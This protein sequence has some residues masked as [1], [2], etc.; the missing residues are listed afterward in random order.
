MSTHGNDLGTNI[1]L[2]RQYFKGPVSRHTIHEAE[3]R[4]GEQRC[5]ASIHDVACQESLLHLTEAWSGQASEYK[6]LQQ[7]ACEHGWAGGLVNGLHERADL[8]H[9]GLE[10][11]V[12]LMDRDVRRGE[13]GIFVQGADQGFVCTVE[14]ALSEWRLECRMNRQRPS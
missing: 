5:E 9:E 8:G 13:P 7:L 11:Q 4:I 2:R 10:E 1:F 3:L 14:A 6:F 12:P